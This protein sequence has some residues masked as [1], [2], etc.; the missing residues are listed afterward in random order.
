MYESKKLLLCRY[1]FNK[2]KI[3]EKY[4]YI[5][6]IENKLSYKISKEHNVLT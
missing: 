3:E 4:E 5:F 1:N 2:L 6:T